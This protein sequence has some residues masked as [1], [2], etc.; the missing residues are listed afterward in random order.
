MKNDP[1]KTKVGKFIEKY[2]I[3]EIPQFFNLII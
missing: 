1:R 2:S 3:D